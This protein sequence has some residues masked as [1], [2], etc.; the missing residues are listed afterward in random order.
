MNRLNIFVI[1]LVFVASL[2][3]GCYD[4]AE[5]PVSTDA[6]IIAFTFPGIH[7]RAEIDV[8]NRCVTAK[9]DET[10]DLTAIVAI[11][12]L[13]DGAVAKVNG[14]YQE[15]RITSNNFTK[16]VMYEIVS[17]CGE[18]VKNWTVTVTG[19]Y[20]KN[21]IS[22]NNGKDVYVA[23]YIWVEEYTGQ[24]K[25]HA[26][27]AGGTF[28]I[29]YSDWRSVNVATLWINGKA[30]HLTDGTYTAHARSVFVSEND[31]YVVGWERNEQGR[32]AAMLWKNGIPKK[33][34]D[35]TDFAGANFVF[36]SGT[37]VYIAGYSN[38]GAAATL[39]KNGVTQDLTDGT[40]ARGAGATSVYVSGND[41]YVSGNVDGKAVFW[42]NG[43]IQYLTTGTNSGTTSI[44]VSGSDVYIVGSEDMN[45]N[46]FSNS[47]AKLWKNGTAQNLTDKTNF[48]G[49]ANSVFVSAGNVYVAGNDRGSIFSGNF[50]GFKNSSATL[51]KNGVVQYHLTNGTNWELASSVFVSGND[52][53]VAGEDNGNAKLWKNRTAQNLGNG[54]ALSVFVK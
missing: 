18:I 17:G 52:V 8:R 39:W 11:L 16:P 53:Y 34:S 30:Q 14:I 9:A 42:K 2:C 36:V 1:G 41:V 15:S 22:N 50:D 23:G 47:I 43:E 32:S 38:G 4:K 26:G 33:L 54:S 46:T 3:T 45:I 35:G 31:V 25:G 24:P 20:N 29:D 48:T 12:T 13:S 44:H 21:N 10:V 37:D 40:S 5:N 7:G 49:W 27:S 28:S 51:W 6:D 19:G